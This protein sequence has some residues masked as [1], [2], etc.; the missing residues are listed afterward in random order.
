MTPRFAAAA[1]AF[2]V[3]SAA[4][5]ATAAPA[6][7]PA[8]SSMPSMSEIPMSLNLSQ[9]ETIALA[10]SPTLA[11]ARGQLESAL[12]A[13]GTARAGELPNISGLANTGRAKS[14]SPPGNFA[15]FTT[16]STTTLT[17]SKS[18]SLALRQLLVDG[19]RIHQAVSAARFNSDAARYDLERQMQSVEFNVASAYYAALQARHQ[20]QVARDSLN[21]A[22]VQLKLVQAQYKAGVASRADVLTA[23]LPVAQAELAVAQ[24]A[25][26]EQTQ[27]AL[28]LDTMGLPAQTPVTISDEPASPAP[29]PALADVL[30]IA[31][32]DRP[33]LLAAQSSADAA[34]ASLRSARLGLFPSISGTGSTNTNSSKQTTDQPNTGGSPPPTIS[35]T[36]SGVYAPSWSVGLSL[37]VPIFD[38]GLTRGETAQA[39]GAVDQANANLKTTQLLV[40]LNIQQAY[41]G[42]Q[43]AQAGLTAA[44]AEY[45]QAKTVLDVT[46]AQ[47]KAGVTTLPLLLNAQVALAKA[48]GDQVNA[49]YTYKTARQQLLIS[50]GTLGQ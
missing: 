46:N 18:A 20:L 31:N 50:E 32:R 33:D 30:A 26:G 17:T 4:R 39:Q 8:P 3:L 23:Q 42:V 7:S 44:D 16:P 10:S 48:E 25:N 24:D 45:A 28:M 41:L 47:Y 27:L 9:A 40:S 49:L 22:Q 29:L 12:G 37:S 38:G 13:V 6:P 15:G 14:V 21:L 19:G 34:A 36:T 1:A 43:T 11:L 5:A 2:L 35:T